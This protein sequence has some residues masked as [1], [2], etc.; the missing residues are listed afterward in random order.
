MNKIRGLIY[1]L[2]GCM[3]IAFG[4]YSLFSDNDMNGRVLGTV[5]FL[6]FGAISLGMKKMKPE[7]EVD[8]EK[9]LEALQDIVD[10]KKAE[11][12]AKSAEEASS[13]T[14]SS[15]EKQAAPQNAN[16]Q[17]NKKH[18]KKKKKKKR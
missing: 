17:K 13:K 3:M 15:Q 8:P 10:E 12:E 11:A 6:G 7:D 4:I 1:V 9:V 16:Q 5:F 14:S 2:F 18:K